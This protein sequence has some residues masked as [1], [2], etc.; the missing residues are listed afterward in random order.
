MPHT[1]STT[2]GHVALRHGAHAVAPTGLVS[3]CPQRVQ[4]M[5]PGRSAYV[6]AGQGVGAVAMVSGQAWPTGHAMHVTCPPASCS[7]GG[8]TE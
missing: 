5:R 3:V 4:F 6:P 1:P 7:K 8:A 2:R